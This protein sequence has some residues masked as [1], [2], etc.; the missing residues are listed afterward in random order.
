M[1]CKMLCRQPHCQASKDCSISSRP[2]CFI[3][4][5]KLSTFVPFKE[6]GSLNI[7]CSRYQTVFSIPCQ[8]SSIASDLLQGNQTPTPYFKPTMCILLESNSRWSQ[9]PLLKK[10]LIICPKGMKPWLRHGNAPPKPQAHDTIWD[11]QLIRRQENMPL[12]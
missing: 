5:K 1:V 12:V 2:F 3:N 8:N 11:Q 7:G 6:T 9:E 4:Q 10:P